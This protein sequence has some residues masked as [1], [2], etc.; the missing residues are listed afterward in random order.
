VT[1]TMMRARHATAIILPAAVL[2]TGCTGSGQPSGAGRAGGPSVRLAAA[3][4][5]VHCAQWRQQHGAALAARFVAAAAV[6]CVQVFRTVHGHN[7]TVWIEREA[8]RDL[9]PLVAALRKPSASPTTAIQCPVPIGPP[10]A[11]FLIDG[12]G[13][14]AQPA[15]PTDGCELPLQQVQTAV[16]HVPWVT[17]HP[18]TPVPCGRAGVRWPSSGRAYSCLNWL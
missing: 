6:Q 15:I 11:L 10:L 2:A 13:Q 8:N 1:K 16:Q 7:R 5:Q 4:R 12:R 14:I 17:V 3:E 18:A 9:A